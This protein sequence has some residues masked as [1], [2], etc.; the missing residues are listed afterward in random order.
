MTKVKHKV[1]GYP[2]KAVFV[3][4]LFSL[5]CAI[6]TFIGGKRERSIIESVTEERAEEKHNTYGSRERQQHY[7][8]LYSITQL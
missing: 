6:K 1:Q 8:Q 3:D 4:K 2:K 7:K 5:M